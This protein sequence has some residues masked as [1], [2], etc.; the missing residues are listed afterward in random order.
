MDLTRELLA[1]QT[2]RRM[3][4]KSHL[5]KR[6][7]GFVIERASFTA[8]SAPTEQCK[9]ANAVEAGMRKGFSS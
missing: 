2:H 6:P 8:A 4:D 1:A 7:N 5:A 9:R 3:I